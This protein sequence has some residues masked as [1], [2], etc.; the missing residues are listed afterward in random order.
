MYIYVYIYF[1]YAFARACLYI[2]NTHVGSFATRYLGSWCCRF[3]HYPLEVTN[4]HTSYLSSTP[5][6][7]SFPLPVI[8]KPPITI[9]SLIP[10]EP[11]SLPPSLPAFSL[12]LVLPSFPSFKIL[13]FLPYFLPLIFVPSF[14]SVFVPPFYLKYSFPLLFLSISFLPCCLPLDFLPSFLPPPRG[15]FLLV[16]FLSSFRPSSLPSSQFR[17]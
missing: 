10:P 15:Y 6:L 3:F 4:T 1:F 13:S 7:P 2:L 14:L 17:S 16:S 9:V 5:P 8:Y 12:P 11:S